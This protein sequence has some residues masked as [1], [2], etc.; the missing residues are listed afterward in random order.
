MYDKSIRINEANSQP[1]SP[2]TFIERSALAH[3]NKTAIRYGDRSFGWSE[4]FDRCKRLAAG[5][6]ARCNGQQETI[7]VMSPNTPAMLEMHFG[8]PMAGCVL[9]T[10][11]Y[12]LD[13]ATISYILGHSNCKILFV[14]IEFAGVAK[15]ALDELAPD[16]RPEVVTL[17]DDLISSAELTDVQSYEDFL[18]S[19]TPLD[20]IELPEDEYSPICINYTSGTTGKPKGVIYHHRGAYLSALGNALAFELSKESNVLWTLPLFHCNGWS[21]AWAVAACG[22]E[23]TCI[24]QINPTDIFKAIN[25]H[26]VSHMSAAP[27]VLNMMQEEAGRSNFSA[28]HKVRIA[29]G[30]APPPSALIENLE[31]LGFHISHLY[32]LTESFGPS[33]ICEH[34]SD[35]DNLSNTDRASKIA[36]QGV[37]LPTDTAVSTRDSK[38]LE[39]TPW[40]GETVGEIMIR[41]NGLMVGYLNDAQAT[42]DAFE[43]GWFHTGDLAVTEPDGAIRITDRIKD[44]IISGGENISSVEIEEVIYAHPQV[45]EV[46]VVAAPDNKWGEVPCAFIELIDSTIP[47]NEAE[48]SAWCRERLASFKI[49]K[50]FDFRVLPKTATGKIQKFKLREIAKK[51]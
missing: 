15:A 24:R 40:D 10:I 8:V 32:G 42:E 3:P 6:R 13:A 23:S 18:T 50:K 1:L 26:N 9:N 45:R 11:N 33:L 20:R 39:E 41:S 43:G 14:D 28:N 49:P 34:Q 29:T 16:C 7:S 2:I 25:T 48:L 44:V 30:G 27:I 22:G 38:T 46:G 4:Y 12:R 36:R 5:L 17:L 35:W 37:R 51:L 47:V 31:E 19:H 21:Q